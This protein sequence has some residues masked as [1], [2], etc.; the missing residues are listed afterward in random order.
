MNTCVRLLGGAL[1]AGLLALPAPS[2]ACGVAPPRDVVV[3]VASESAIIVWD[4]QTK[5]EHFI[6]RAT[7][8]AHAPGSTPVKDFG[9]LVP[10]PSAPALEEVDDSAFTELARVTEPRTEVRAPPSGG[11][12]AL[13]CGGEAPK[14]A[15]AG[16]D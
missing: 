12:C 14:S 13:G 15:A 4:E 8:T 11:G 2:D 7:F 9:F 16:R 5:T 3:E 6:R 1:L 10:T